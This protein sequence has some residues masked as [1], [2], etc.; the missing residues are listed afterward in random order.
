[1]LANNQ[2][3]KMQQKKLSLSVKSD[4]MILCALLNDFFLVNV[5]NHTYNLYILGNLVITI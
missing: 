4:L 1:M 2:M 5:D 3:L